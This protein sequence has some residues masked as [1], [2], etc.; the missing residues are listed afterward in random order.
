MWIT[1]AFSLA[2]F[3]ALNR[4]A[5]LGLACLFAFA[6]LL[7]RRSDARP[8]A[9]SAGG[10]GRPFEFALVSLLIVPFYLLTLD[11]EVSWDADVYH[12]TLPR[13]FIAH[14]GFRSVPFNVYSHW[15]LGAELLYAVAMLAKDYVL[16]KLV[17]FAFGA[18]T[19]YAIA[20]GCREFHRGVA[21]PLAHRGVA[22]PLAHRGVAAPL[23]AL[24]FLA[25]P[26]VLT[27]LHV[28]YVD[29]AYA[30]FF[31]AG[32]LF[33]LRAT[34]GEGDGAAHWLLA[35]ICCG[36]VAGLKVTGIVA[37]AVVGSLA[38]PSLVAAYRSG[39]LGSVVGTLALRF[40]LP[41]LV[42]W[43]PWLVKAWLGT[44]NPVYPFGYALFGG[45]EW[46]SGLAIQFSQWQSSIGMGR[47]V[48]DYI[49]LPMRVILEG[50]VDYPHF[51]GRIGAFWIVVLPL[52]LAL[53]MRTRL[54][55]CALLVSGLYFVV[56]A[57][58][59]QQMR[60]LVPILPLL[61]MAGAIAICDGIERIGKSWVSWIRVAV[62]CVFAGVFVVLYRAPMSRGI[63]ISLWSQ[64]EAQTR[65]GEHLAINVGAE[66]IWLESS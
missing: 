54:V 53:G 9:P 14:G 46:S 57:F 52:A 17:H 61:A 39:L 8:L 15:P 19:L 10:G 42:L 44:G 24:L 43:L 5:V 58:S 2:A 6:A 25:N 27:E 41:V 37:A 12:L 26:V 30:F 66:T 50:G 16:A 22:A 1:A 65:A 34:A 7:A 48:L 63:A 35:G 4:F 21:A 31:T 45:I 33:A 36:V 60:F 62:L 3:G 20:V 23:A 56:W 18:A 55:R 32:F 47:D 13:L 40:V 38:V 29:L 11:P 59:S 49:L 51:D 28:A 64:T